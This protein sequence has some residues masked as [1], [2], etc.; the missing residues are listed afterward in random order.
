MERVEADSP[1]RCQ[2]ITKIGQCQF[3]R[4]EHS[5]YCSIHGGNHN[6][7]LRQFQDDI[8][9]FSSSE[10]IKSLKEEI[11]ILRMMLEKILNQCSDAHDL[12]VYYAQI[13][14]LV[15]KIDKVVSSCHK[16]EAASG[17]LLDKEVVLNIAMKIVDL[18][19]EEV[20]PDRLVL[21]IPS[22]KELLRDPK[23][24]RLLDTD[25]SE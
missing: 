20:P 2:G 22:I 18:F 12:L 16:I 11:A 3:K 9:R 25:S 5:K 19:S 6:Y 7:R 1:E 4:A 10:K 21:L 8:R 15:D 23:D 13:V 24:S 14:T 17:D